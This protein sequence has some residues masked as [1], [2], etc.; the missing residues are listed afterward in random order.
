MNLAK[1]PITM[2]TMYENPLYNVEPLQLCY[3]YL[4]H[5]DLEILHEFQH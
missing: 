5:F 2:L 3:P 4:E 1:I